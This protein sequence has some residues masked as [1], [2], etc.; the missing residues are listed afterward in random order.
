[1]SPTLSNSGDSDINDSVFGVGN[2]L[3]TLG[4]HVQQG[5]SS[6]VLSV[7]LHL[8]SQLF[9]HPTNDTPYLTGNEKEN[10]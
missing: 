9:I 3:V 6:W 1:M 10:I 2:S 7:T 8:T 5:Y 4:V